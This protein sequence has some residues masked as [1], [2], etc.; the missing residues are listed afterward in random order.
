MFEI[1][2]LAA[3]VVVVWI[4]VRHHSRREGLPPKANLICESWKAAEGHTKPEE[5][6]EALFFT[7]GFLFH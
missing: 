7:D 2:I 6:Q 1:L 5:R 3:A 4:L